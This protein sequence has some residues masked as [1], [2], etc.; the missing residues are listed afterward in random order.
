MLFYHQ[1][2]L[3]GW[4]LTPDST[5]GA[6]NI[7]P[8]VTLHPQGFPPPLAFFL[9]YGPVLTHLL[10]CGSSRDIRSVFS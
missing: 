8:G 9:S 5:G 1:N 6:Y 7:Q 4:E 2:A 10:T 3:G